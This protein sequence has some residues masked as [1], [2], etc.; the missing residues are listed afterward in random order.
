MNA[1]L[2]TAWARLGPRARIAAAL[3]I[4][5]VTL[6]VYI[7]LLVSASHAR[8]QLRT[9]VAALRAAEARMDADA[10]EYRRLR[11]M[12]APAAAQADL[13]L[14]VQANAGLGTLT[15]D[16]VRVD[17][18]DPNHAKI[19]HGAVSFADW[20]VWVESLHSQRIRLQACR[21]DALTTPGLVNVS[22]TLAR[23]A[24]Q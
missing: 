9:S 13:A 21:V 5:G 16:R 1:V 20:L 3:L 6:L 10:A 17:V 14:V 4:A 22:A 24:P 19:V 8:E 18:T 11:G 2:S 15:R 12:A 7:A 23:A